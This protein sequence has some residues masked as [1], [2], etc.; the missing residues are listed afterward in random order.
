[1]AKTQALERRSEVMTPV[2]RFPTLHRYQLQGDDIARR[3]K[4]ATRGA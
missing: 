2:L 1:M 3:Q 4:K